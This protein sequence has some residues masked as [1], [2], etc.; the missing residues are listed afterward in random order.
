MQRPIYL[1]EAPNHS[2]DQGQHH[3]QQRLVRRDHSYVTGDAE[4]P[5]STL[6]LATLLPYGFVDPMLDAWRVQPIVVV[7]AA[8]VAA[9]VTHVGNQPAIA[10]VPVWMCVQENRASGVA[11]AHVAGYRPQSPGG[12]DDSS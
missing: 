12:V 2:N 11:M 10:V 1:S 7:L 5:R 8:A 6:P 9:A 4:F 3:G